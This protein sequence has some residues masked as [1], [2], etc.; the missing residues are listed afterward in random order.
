MGHLVV[1][2]RGMPVSVLLFDLGGVLV[3]YSGLEDLQPLLPEPMAQADLLAR[4]I[5]CPHSL[6]Y[7]AGQLTTDEFVVRFLRDWRISVEPAAFLDA[8]DSWVRGWLPG[9]A[10]LIEDL[11]PRY[12]LAALSNSNPRTGT[13]W[14]VWACSMRSIRRS[15]RISSAFASLTP[16][17]STRPSGALTC[18]LTPSCSSMTAGPTS[19]PRAR[20]ACR[21]RTSTA[22]PRY[23]ATLQE[24]RNGG[25]RR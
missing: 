6:A 3:D 14:R 4:W 9:A 25:V 19:K 22:P 24:H 2:N 13:G 8:W 21:P 20:S 16:R 11:R 12:R 18:P 7:G 5:A 1:H 17:S 23:A 10:A 15:G